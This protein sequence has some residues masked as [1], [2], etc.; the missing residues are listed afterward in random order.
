[1][2]SFTDST[3]MAASSLAKILERGGARGDGSGMIIATLRAAKQQTRKTQTRMF[4]DQQLESALCGRLARR[5]G[6]CVGA[7]SMRAVRDLEREIA[8]TL[9]GD[10]RSFDPSMTRKLFGTS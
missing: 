2:H 5:F 1:M 9:W 10:L 3:S 6:E 8:D 7:R 4:M